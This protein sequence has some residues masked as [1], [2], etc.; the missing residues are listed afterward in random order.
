M[1]DFVAY[2]LAG[3][4]DVRRL[5]L[6][7]ISH[8]AFTKVYRLMLNNTDDVTVTLETDE[9]ATFEYAPIRIRPIGSSDDLG[10]AL[11]FE[12][13][14]LGEIVPTE[15]DAVAELGAYRIKPTVLYRV[16]REDDLSA[17][18][19][20]PYVLEAGQLNFAQGGVSFDAKAPSVNITRTGENYRVDRFPMLRGVL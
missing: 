1:P 20:G 6:F 10:Q 3:P 15:L 5:E 11:R 18:M 7:E 9:E 8:P 14:D 16:Y 2:F 17:P 13:G 12:F 19:D 4:A